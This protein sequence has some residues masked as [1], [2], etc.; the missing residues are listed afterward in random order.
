[1]INFYR[2]TACKSAHEETELVFVPSATG[3]DSMPSYYSCPS[4]G[5][6]DLEPVKECEHCGKFYDDSETAFY[7]CCN[8]CLGDALKSCGK[9]ASGTATGVEKAAVAILCEYVRE[10]EDVA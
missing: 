9:Y 10:L 4:C 3:E 2:C 1:M 5:N 8:C 7:G 6:D